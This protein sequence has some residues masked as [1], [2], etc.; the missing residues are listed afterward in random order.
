MF[1]ILL[2]LEVVPAVADSPEAAEAPEDLELAHLS[3][4]PDRHIQLQLV[5]AVLQ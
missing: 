5:P 3:P 1:S 4:L 2:W